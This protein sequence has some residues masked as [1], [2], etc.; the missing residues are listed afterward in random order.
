MLC[1]GLYVG[2]STAAVPLVD[3]P[4][5]PPESDQILVEGGEFLM[6]LD[7]A[8]KDRSRQICDADREVCPWSLFD[9][10]SPQ[11]TLQL[12]PYFIDK[13]ETTVAE[14]RA[15]VDA[16][17]CEVPVS[18]VYC[19]WSLPKGEAHPINCVTWHQAKAYCEWVGKR[20]PTEAEW[21]RAARGND[22]RLFPWG[23]ELPSEM[24][25][26]VGNFSGN[27]GHDEN[28][29]WSLVNDFDDG[30]VA[31]TKVG[32]FEGGLSPFGAADM[33][34]NVAEWVEDHYSVSGY[35]ESDLIDPRGAEDGPG[36]VVR[37]GS[38]ADDSVDIRTTARRAGAALG[39]YNIVGFRCARSAE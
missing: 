14:Y 22:G 6:G 35:D 5:T 10:E 29:M 18:T 26:I 13:F 3:V 12:S 7:D 33:A 32:S 34:G 15:C 24:P 28:P 8:Q 2:C 1:A 21:E 38:F 39:P 36:R 37:G 17:V 11:R 25:M 27:S 4:I 30:S 31:S 20:L 9:I 23:N 16:E 19:T